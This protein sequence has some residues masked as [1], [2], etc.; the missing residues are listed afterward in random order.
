M[1]K[2]FIIL[3]FLL[4]IPQLVYAHCPLCTGAVGAA[5][6]T[7]NYY[8]LDNSIIGIFIGAFAISTGLWFGLKVKKKYFFHFRE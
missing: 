7:A 5:A 1:K 4:I 6:V 3:M 2:I 8:G